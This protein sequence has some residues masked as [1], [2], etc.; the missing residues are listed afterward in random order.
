MQRDKRKIAVRVARVIRELE[1]LYGL[2]DF[3]QV[4]IYFSDKWVVSE[5]VVVSCSKGYLQ[6]YGKGAPSFAF[7]ESIKKR[8]EQMGRELEE[9]DCLC[10][11]IFVL[12]NDEQDF[13]LEVVNNFP[14]KVTDPSLF[15]KFPLLGMIQLCIFGM[16]VEMVEVNVTKQMN[17]IVS[18][19]C[20]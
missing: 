6:L 17:K 20:K 4:G 18:R 15:K 10:G 3:L 13:E 12:I 9:L 19:Y 16:P 1:M 8:I 7:T 5:I 14:K 2:Y 11:S